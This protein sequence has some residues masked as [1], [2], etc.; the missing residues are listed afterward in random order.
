[1]PAGLFL[2]G[3]L[4]N[5]V[6]I[7]IDGSNFLAQL[8]RCRLGYPV[9]AP[10]ISW[11]RDTDQFVYARFYSA[12]QDLEPFR[13]RW[14]RFRSA[15]RHITGLDFFQGYRDRQNRE[16]VIDVALAVDL[17][18][19]CANN[20][21]DHVALVGGDA[22]H[23]YAVKIARAMRR[24]VK[25]WLMPSQ[26]SENLAA[27][28]IPYRRMS[29]HDLVSRGIADRGAQTAVPADHHAPPASPDVTPRF[30]GAFAILV[31]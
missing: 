19:G 30:T 3:D 29:V 22:D 5:R 28:R 12:P 1:V 4:V 20:H 15:N 31:S 11:I 9:L 23:H 17:I 6:A 26:P 18:Y 24:R 7:L 16:K 21:F 27:E 8:D 10:L 2:C 14:Q 25:V 13:S